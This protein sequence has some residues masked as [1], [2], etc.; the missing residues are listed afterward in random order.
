[1]FD[2]LYWELNW[3]LGFCG[4]AA[5]HL[6]IGLNSQSVVRPIAHLNN[7]WAAQI[8]RPHDAENSLGGRGFDANAHHASSALYDDQSRLISEKCASMFY[9]RDMQNA[10]EA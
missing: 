5:H 4:R 1:M 6:G 9:K 8:E 2:S 7:S 3:K 10:V